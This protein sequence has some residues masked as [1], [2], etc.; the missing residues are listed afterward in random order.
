MKTMEGKVNIPT[1]E[2]QLLYYVHL[3]AKSFLESTD[4]VFWEKALK[5]AV[6]EFEAYKKDK[7]R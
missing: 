1:E 3:T 2:F 6:D 7:W 5:E 4:K